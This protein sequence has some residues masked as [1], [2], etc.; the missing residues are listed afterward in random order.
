MDSYKV[1]SLK[2]GEDSNYSYILSN[3]K[4]GEALAVDPAWDIEKIENCLTDE[5]TLLKA[6]LLTHSHYDHINLVEPL[7]EK[8]QCQVYMSRKEAEFKD[9]RCKN[10]NLLD[11]LEI[12]HIC[13]IEAQCLLTPGH[14]PGSVC[15]RIDNH[16]F[17]GDTLFVRACGFCNC[18]GGN[19]DDMFAS[20]SK[21][22]ELLNKGTYIHPGHYF[23]DDLKYTSECSKRNIYLHIKDKE[24]FKRVIS[25]SGGKNIFFE[26]E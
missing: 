16:L 6:I 13:G 11:D 1:V 25:I 23:K 10:L 14:T 4:T 20:I 19:L 21:L 2:V 12:I 15:Y 8:Y 26:Y 9:F 17:T 24:V 7:V 5:N 22:R 3:L 18:K